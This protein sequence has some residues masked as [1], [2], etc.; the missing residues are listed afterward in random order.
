MVNPRSIAI[1]MWALSALLAAAG[2]YRSI[3]ERPNAAF[4]AVAAMFFI[5]GLAAKRRSVE[6]AQPA[7]DKES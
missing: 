6:S 7:P 5:I 1:G 3:K 4:I 2:I